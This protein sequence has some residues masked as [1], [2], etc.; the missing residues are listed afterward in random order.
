MVRAMGP[1]APRI[2]NGP[3]HGGRCPRPGMRPG[4]G[5]NE[6]MPVKCAGTRTEPPLSLPSPA[7]E[8]PAAMAADSPPL[9]PPGDR[10]RSH[11]FRVRPCSRFAV[12]YAIRNSGQFVVPRINAPAARSRATTTASS[13]GISPLCSRLPISHR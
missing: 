4:V 12:S 11:G 3:T 2:E 5:L 6:Q 13:R 8:I 10:S 7:A 9:D 1:I